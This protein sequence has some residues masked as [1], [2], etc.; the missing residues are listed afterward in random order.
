MKTTEYRKIVPLA[1]ALAVCIQAGAAHPS[2]TTGSGVVLLWPGGAP[3]AVGSEEV[4][5]PKLTVYPS[6]ARQSN[7]TAVIVCPGGGYGALAVDHEG[8]QV[9][10]W[11][12]SLGVTA[13]ILKY[14]LGP[15]Y[16]HPVPL[17][18]AQRAVRT[19]RRERANGK[20]TPAASVCGGSPPAAIS[21]RLPAPI[22][23]PAW[24]IHRT[25][26]SA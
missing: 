2:G 7:G 3:L 8:K 23:I 9:A 12:N 25:P 14:R 20:S 21:P 19:V 13:F 26:S 6:E 5:R 22:S 16:H 17:L 10:K 1:A 11:L 24:P 15:R 18:D 4:D